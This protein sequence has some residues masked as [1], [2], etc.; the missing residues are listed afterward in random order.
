M[1]VK[2]VVL[3]S[4]I[5]IAALFAMILVPLIAYLMYL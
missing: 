4:I 1:K 2:H 3:L 5:I